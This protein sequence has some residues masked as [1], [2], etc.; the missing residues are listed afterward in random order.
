MATGVVSWSKTAASNGT[1][2]ANINFAEGMAASQLDDSCRAVMASVAKYRDDING[3]LVTGGTS[4]AYTITSN[5]VFPSLAAM[6]G[7]TI[8]VNFNATNGAA[9]TLNVDQLGAKALNSDT[10][11]AIL[12]GIIRANTVWALTYNNSSGVWL[13]QNFRPLQVKM[14]T[15]VANGTYT[16]TT[17]MLYCRAIAV[18]AGGGGGGAAGPGTGISSGGGGGGGVY[19]ESILT[20]AQIGASK[21]VTVSSGGGA[22]GA[23]GNNAGGT[24]GNSSLGSLVVAAGGGGGGGGPDATIG[25]SGGA[26]GTS[27]ATGF[28]TFNGNPGQAGGFAAAGTVAVQSGAGGSAIWPCGFFPGT[29]SPASGAV[30]NGGGGNTG[31]GGSGGITRGTASNASGG[32]GGSGI[33]VIYEYCF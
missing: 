26:A 33:V 23:A 8:V 20:A 1:A 24:G 18:G 17:N 29:Q 30:A 3:S 21:P 9:P 28:L 31:G 4:T 32:Q 19:A 27:P 22:G 16:P 6:D 7:Q 11:T 10:S 14:Q 12:T 25:G 5:Q 2:D 15:F 13:I